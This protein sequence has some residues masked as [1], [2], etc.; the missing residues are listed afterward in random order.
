MNSFRCAGQGSSTLSGSSR[1]LF[2]EKWGIGRSWEKSWEEL[3]GELAAAPLWRAVGGGWA[4]A[5]LQ[6]LS[7]CPWHREPS[8]CLA[9]SSYNYHI[10]GWKAQKQKRL[11][12]SYKEQRASFW[13]YPQRW[14]KQA[15]GNVLGALPFREKCSKSGSHSLKESNSDHQAGQEALLPIKPTHR[16]TAQYYYKGISA[17]KH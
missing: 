13:L 8:K 5:P 4:V 16:S 17:I 14:G 2:K 12:A 3:G 9:R 6:R 15:W 1:G 10:Y 7:P 11:F